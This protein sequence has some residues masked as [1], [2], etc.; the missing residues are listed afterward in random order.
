MRVLVYLCL[1][2]LAGLVTVEMM[3][4]SVVAGVCLGVIF[5]Y[6]GSNIES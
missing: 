5:L 1:G 2:V 4:V 6:V 3:K